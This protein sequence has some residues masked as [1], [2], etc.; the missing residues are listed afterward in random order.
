MTGGFLRGFV[1]VAFLTLSVVLVANGVRAEGA[2]KPAGDEHSV[3]KDSGSP[4]QSPKAV[5]PLA[6]VE[7]GVAKIGK[8]TNSPQPR[9]VEEKFKDWSLQCIEGSS[10]TPPCQIMYRL[11]SSN[12]KQVALVLSVARSPKGKISLQM[13]LPLGFSI[14]QGVDLA[15]GK[16]YSTVAR[17]S[18]CTVQGCLV[19]GEAPAKMIDAMLHG[20]NGVVSVHN[21][22]GRQIKL[23]ISLNGFSTAFEALKGKG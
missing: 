1:S 15:F 19:E 14:S 16:K 5:R 17:V 12:Q 23:P 10:A 4:P 11:T 13:A 18:R 22:E 2:K 3:G 20:S 9:L 21:M 7:S 6:P 8:P